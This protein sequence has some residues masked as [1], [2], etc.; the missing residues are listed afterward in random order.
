M[1]KILLLLGFGLL[2]LFSCQ[3]DRL[4]KEKEILVGTWDWDYSKLFDNCDG[5]IHS[6]EINPATENDT[7]QVEFLKRGIIRFY[8][9][10]VLTAEHNIVFH[11]AEI[12]EGGIVESNKEIHVILHLDG[13]EDKALTIKGTPKEMR[14]SNYPFTYINDC[15]YGIRNILKKRY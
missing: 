2:L 10:D 6:Q 12:P 11:Y 4:S 15:T 7:Y 13:D 3:K 9:N 8:K 14:F 1:K 5:F